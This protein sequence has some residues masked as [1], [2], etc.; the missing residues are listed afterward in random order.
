MEYVVL[1]EALFNKSV[2]GEAYA[3]HEYVRKSVFRFRHNFEQ[4]SM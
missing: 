3:H 4:N 1:R 2:C